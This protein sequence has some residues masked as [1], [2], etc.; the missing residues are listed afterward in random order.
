MSY[1]KLSLSGFVEE[2]K[3]V[4]TGAHPRKFC[5]VLGAGAS[6]SSGIK[7]GRELVDIWDRELLERNREG[8][9]AWKKD[10]GINGENKY[11]FYSQYYERRFRL[12]GDGYNYLEK[13]MEHASPNIGYVMLSYLLSHTDHNVVI[14]TNF[15]HLIE[16]AVNYYEHTIPLVIGHESLAHYVTKQINRPMIIKIH[17][18]LL[19]DPKNRIDE[20]GKLHDHW[21]RALD[22]VFSEYHPVFIGYAGNDK[23]LMDFLNNNSEKILKQ[24]WKLPYWMLYKTDKMSEDVLNF[25]NESEGYLIRHNGFDKVL[26]LLGAAS[27]Y[28]VPTREEFLSDAE[29]RFELL[30]DS[31]D[32]FTEKSVAGK[33]TDQREE[34]SE[35][36]T[37][38][39]EIGE[40][41]QRVTNQTEQQSLYRKALISSRNGN[42][43]EA[44][45]IYKELIERNP[46]NARYHNSLGI[47]LQGMKRYEEALGEKQRAVEMEPENAQYHDSLSTTLH[48]M[49][50]YKEALR[51]TQK[52]LEL[53]PENARYH[54]S[55][56][57][58]LH[59]M[60]K[61]EEAFKEKR[62]AV[63]LEPENARY[64]DSLGATLHEMGRYE[65]ALEETQR[66]V[67]LEPENVRYCEGLSVVLYKM[68]R[69]E[70]AL[71]ET[72]R[73]LEL[74]PD[75]AVFHYFLGSILEKLGN[76]EEAEKEKQRADE[77]RIDTEGSV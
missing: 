24:E 76:H 39:S 44:I 37:D 74:E 49:K 5:F 31:I 27:G 48:K 73:V 42:Y 21:K 4:S 38:D 16:D 33:E 56:G 46:D 13:M 65:E 28:S 34:D 66:A 52:A 6:K 47:A 14:T 30:V 8:H 11:E 60:E 63:E 68:G 41:I 72:R 12:P 32:E 53:E 22:I 69:Y 71:E 2:M 75:N 3:M 20:V 23:S 36:G 18:D 50:R 35:E 19:L 70:E 61:Y 77:L 29:K 1:E 57:V 59:E 10:Q 43:E 64:Y 55:L 51:E 9:L 67:E 58:T 62:K 26:Y 40:A 54:D 45:Q 25:L 15:D 7:P 17:R